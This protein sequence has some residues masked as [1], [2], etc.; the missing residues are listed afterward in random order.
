LVKQS[1]DV[2]E[3]VHAFITSPLVRV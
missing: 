2:M 1:L 3:A